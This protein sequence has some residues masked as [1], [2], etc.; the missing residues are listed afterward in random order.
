MIP[1]TTTPDAYGRR[2]DVLVPSP[3]RQAYPLVPLTAF[4]I[5]VPEGARTVVMAATTDV[6][7]QYDTVAVVPTMAVA[8]G[9]APELNPI[10]RDVSRVQ[11][12]SIIAANPGAISLG[13]YG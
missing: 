6:W 2:T 12:I 11:E 4:A 5:P 8:D 3:H 1:F 10:A 9:N 13:F 7:V